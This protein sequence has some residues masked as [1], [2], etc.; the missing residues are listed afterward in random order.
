V[1][2]V[3][4]IDHQDEE[5]VNFDGDSYIT[6]TFESSGGYFVANPNGLVCAVYNPD[7][8][9]YH[10]D[11][12]MPSFTTVDL[13]GRLSLGEHTDLGASVTN[14]FNRMAPFDPYT[15]GGL[16]YNPAFN[17]AGA[18]GRFMTITARYRF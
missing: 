14:L 10:G 6:T 4:L 1:K 17:Q 15:Y 12:R 11:C 9:P 16:N 18:L 7:G 13:V 3:K 2:G 8:T 5:L